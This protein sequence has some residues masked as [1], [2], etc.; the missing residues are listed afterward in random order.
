MDSGLLK[1]SPQA[2]LLEDNLT[3]H[4]AE[5]AALR[6]LNRMGSH[7]A[8]APASGNSAP[9][10]NDQQLRLTPRS[11]QDAAG[12]FRKRRF[13]RD[14]DVQV[15]HNP[16]SRPSARNAPA[17]SGDSETKLNN[18]AL[19]AERRARN[20]AERQVQELETHQ[21]SLETRLGHAQVLVAEL[22]ESLATREA[23]L[24][25]VKMELAGEQLALQQAHAEIRALRQQAKSAPSKTASVQREVEADEE[26][27]KPVKWWKD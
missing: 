2:D 18:R 19:E 10:Q 22:K 21:R 12:Q 24:A 16:F 20:D 17:H 11:G 26:G 9:R 14:G 27:Q 15:E 5:E 7:K 13:V 3:D 23:E 1:R 6:A 8:N 4:D 25:A